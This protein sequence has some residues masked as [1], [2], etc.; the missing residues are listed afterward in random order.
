MS[1]FLLLLA[2]IT[3]ILA[4]G[5][6]EALANGAEWPTVTIKRDFRG[7]GHYL[8]WGKII[9]CW[10]VFLTWVYST[11]WVS[12]DGQELKLAFLRWKF[13]NL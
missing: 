5:A 12:R 3:A 2:V 4:L 11:D 6:G 7:P 9:A 1:R 10:L 8:G 13:Y